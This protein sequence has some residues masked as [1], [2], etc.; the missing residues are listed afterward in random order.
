MCCWVDTAGA[1]YCVLSLTRVV[2]EVYEDPQAPEMKA[3]HLS[4]WDMCATLK[5][6]RRGVAPGR[7]GTWR[8][9]KQRGAC[10][11]LT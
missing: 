6:T 3:R 1:V 11:N 8:K 5:Q 4:L 7:S 9:G 10:A 2:C